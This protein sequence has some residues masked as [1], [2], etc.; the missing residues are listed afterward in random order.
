MVQ[1]QTQL[2]YEWESWFSDSV[3]DSLVQS[4]NEVPAVARL[5]QEL[6]DLEGS[7]AWSRYSIRQLGQAYRMLQLAAQ[8][9]SEQD[10]IET[11][12]AMRAVSG[13]LAGFGARSDRDGVGSPFVRCVIDVC[14]TFEQ[15][16]VDQLRSRGFGDQ[17]IA[18]IAG[19][20]AL[21]LFVSLLNTATEPAHGRV[22]DRSMA[23]AG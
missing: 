2:G 14:G 1:A 11:Q 15:S 12:D 8:L 18:E 16:E 9:L 4:M 17:E 22:R 3:L 13:C 5:L 6:A 10:G 23:Y 20:V 21:K 19:A 7:W